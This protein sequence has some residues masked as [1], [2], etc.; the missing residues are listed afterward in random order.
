MYI[1]SIGLEV[2]V[3]LKTRTKM[4]CGCS[5]AYGAPPNSQVCP[6]CLGYPGAMPVMNAEAVRL[7]VLSGLMLGC[8]IS[9]YS[10]FDRKSY[11][12]PD[13]PKNYQITQYDRPLCLGGGLD[14]ETG[15]QTRRVRLTRIHLEEDVGKSTHHAS[16]S[17]VDFNRAGVPLMEI[18]TEPDLASADEAMAFLL[19]LRQTLLYAGV[20]DCNLEEGNLRCDVNISVRP[21]GADKLG[22]KAEIKNMN[23][24]KGVHAALLHEIDRQTRLVAGGGRVAQ[25]TLRWDPDA[26][27]TFPMRGKEDAHDYRYFPEPDLLPVVLAREQVEAWRAT[28]PER[29][30]DRRTRL[31]QTYGIPVYDAGVLTADRAVADFFEAAARLCNN[32]KAAS[33]WIMTDV[34]R[35]LGESGHTLEQCRL[36]PEML[37]ELIL[38]VERRT[39]NQPTAKG[40]LPELFAAGG[41]PGGLVAARGLG[42][43]GGADEIGRLVDQ[44]IAASP[45]TVQ[46]FLAG[47][48]AAAQSLVG[49]VMKLSRGKADPQLAGKLVA[50]KLAARKG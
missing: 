45:K 19:A 15:G 26:G 13:M 25:Q 30:A 27:A 37:A 1:P 29:P 22:T 8:E 48:Q 31:V 47:K 5:T 12:Y 39:I 43:M 3:Q 16:C 38:L 10:K 36:T 42:Q 6:V 49:Q 46:D 14:F 41:S 4:F 17:G 2:H 24:F 28:L 21:E 40:L 7:T 33:N 9:D 34:L 20:G 35:L 44:A 50:E 23:T 11:F 32:G 18:V